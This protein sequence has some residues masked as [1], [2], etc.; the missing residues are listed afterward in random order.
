MM[1]AI[2]CI[3]TTSTTG[4]VIIHDSTDSYRET[5]RSNAW[6]DNRCQSSPARCEETNDVIRENSSSLPEYWSIDEGAGRSQ[7]SAPVYRLPTRRART[8]G[9]SRRN[10]HK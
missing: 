5:A 1:A 2:V 3:G 6:S 7:K 10:Y 4:L 9:W 8:R